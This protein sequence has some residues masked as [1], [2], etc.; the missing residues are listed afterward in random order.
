MAAECE[1]EQSENP[2]ADLLLS[3]AH[4][5]AVLQDQPRHIGLRNSLWR[6]PEQEMADQLI[7][8]ER[9]AYR[10]VRMPKSLTTYRQISPRAD[11]FA[12]GK[13][14][15]LVLDLMMLFDFRIRRQLD[16]ETNLA[17]DRQVNI[18]PALA[19]ADDE[20]PLFEIDIVD[21]QARTLARSHAREQRKQMIAAL[22][23][24]FDLV[25]LGTPCGIV[26][27]VESDLR[28]L[29]AIELNGLRRQPCGQMNVSFGFAIIDRPNDPAA[30]S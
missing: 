17:R 1:P 20:H 16:R 6:V 3:F 28:R 9:R 22:N 21:R 29:I 13:Q 4:R 19:V 7:D 12:S 18:L 30:V 23:R 8:P 27:K 11:L 10:A 15:R 24:T 25:P 14:Q 26:A 2:R 5:I